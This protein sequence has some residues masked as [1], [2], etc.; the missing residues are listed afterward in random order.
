M[1]LCLH[2]PR[3]AH[4]GAA[5][6]QMIFS[7]VLMSAAA[8]A[9]TPVVPPV[10]A[11]AAGELVKLIDDMIAGGRATK[12]PRPPAYEHQPSSTASYR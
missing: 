10:P 3:R 7:L 6:K 11:G 4:R 5:M 9:Q 8:F 12:L 1:T 2:H